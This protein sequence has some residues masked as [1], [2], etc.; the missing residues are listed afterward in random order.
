MKK[1]V[2]VIIKAYE[3]ESLELSEISDA[4][5]NDPNYSHVRQLHARGGGNPHEVAV[6]VQLQMEVA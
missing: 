3:D 2:D 4:T 5:V 6:N 1:P